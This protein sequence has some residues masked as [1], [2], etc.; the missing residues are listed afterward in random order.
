MKRALILANG[1]SPSARLFNQIHN[2]DD[3]FV[4]ADGGANHAARFGKMPHLIIGDL[5]SITDETLE[6]FKK[7]R[8]KK[9]KEQNSTDLEKAFTITI[10]KGYTDIIVLGATGGRL[11]HAIG[12]LSA[13]AKF[14]RSANI[15]FIDNSGVFIPVGRSLELNIPVKTTISL[16]PL[17][18]CSN[19]I[20]TGL[21]WNLKNESLQLGQRESTSNIVASSPVTIHVSRGDLILYIMENHKVR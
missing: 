12:N 19:I 18:R 13:L 2:S 17:S 7:A 3:W 10:R 9:L 14:S 6:L 21:K 8:I 1:E 20:T 16:L 4:C 15:K 5:D 11:D